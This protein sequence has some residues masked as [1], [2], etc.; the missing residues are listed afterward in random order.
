MWN[1]D[2]G[3]MDP[4]KDLPLMANTADIRVRHYNLNLSVSFEKHVLSGNVTLFL[5]TANAKEAAEGVHV[6]PNDDVGGAPPPAKRGRKNSTAKAAK[7][8]RGQSSTNAANAWNNNF[9]FILDSCDISV[10][11]VEEVFITPSGA[12]QKHTHSSSNNV[13]KSRPCVCSQPLTDVLGFRRNDFATRN[14]KFV[15]ST[16]HT[17]RPLQFAVEPWCVRIWKEGVTEAK[18]FPSCI[19]IYYQTK[20]NGKSLTWAFDQAGRECVFTQGAWINNRS[21]FPCQ[22]PPGAMATWQAT[23][24][25]PAGWVALMSGDQ[26]AQTTQQQNG[27]R[28]Y[29][30]H[31][32]MPV[33]ASVLALAIGYWKSAGVPVPGAKQRTMITT[34][35]RQIFP[36]AELDRYP[37]TDCD[38]EPWPCRIN[39]T[40]QPV[41]PSRIYAPASILPM[42]VTE[43]AE[44]IPRYMSALFEML[45]AHPFPRLDVVIMPKCFASIGLASPSIVFVS[46]TLIT[47]DGSLRPRLAHEISHSWFGILIGAKDWTEEW[48]S[49]G[50]ATYMEDPTHALAEGWTQ[51]QF[52][53]YSNL[54]SLIRFHALKAEL[55]NTVAE[56]QI[57]RP[58][59]KGGGSLP[60]G[61]K[62]AFVKNGL[63]PDKWFL[64]VH[65]LK[66]YF[67][68]QYLAKHIGAA[69]LLNVIRAYVHKYHGKLVLSKEIFTLMFDM[70]PNLKSK[71]ITM[72]MIY[73]DW[74]DC[75]GMPKALREEDFTQGNSL[76]Q[77]VNDVFQK[78]L[79]IDRYHKR[80]LKPSKKKPKI[81]IPAVEPPL[82]TQKLSP[83]QLTLLME[84]FLTLNNRISSKTLASLKETYK[85]C[86]ANPESRHRWCE[87]VTKH[88]YADGYGDIRLFLL[89]DQAMGVYLYGELMA[90]ED[91]VQQFLAEVCFQAVSKEMDRG[92]Y[93]TVHQML[94]GNKTNGY[95]YEKL[96]R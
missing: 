83:D 75:S 16:T 49:E 13:D 1:L 70:Y 35:R 88:Y 10:S 47:G 45:G 90:H 46:Q 38:H 22:E 77:Q 55:Q 86:T 69:Q 19:K 53:E 73:K 71:G 65:Y 78:W 28:A 81:D 9:T 2:P 23:I 79:D 41:V 76:V 87:L 95:L 21:L 59:G 34:C 57:M 60:Q 72:D 61:G 82:P 84:Q 5:E 91:P 36:S 32:N 44:Y 62:M 85:L 15:E 12:D 3:G 54:R 18:N 64:Q 50:F 27:D 52:K 68:L 29:S 92:C 51:Q 39:R 26:E 4:N 25:A 43:F 93:N 42:A 20:P 6:S 30:Y 96:K 8:Q 66:G 94:Y 48:L 58:M 37:K 14:K 67:L 11:K 89:E 80:P 24:H 74:L 31:T 56:L 63:N 40:D 17:G 7:R 33:P